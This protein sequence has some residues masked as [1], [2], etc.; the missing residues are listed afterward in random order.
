MSSALVAVTDIR[1]PAPDGPAYWT[2]SFYVSVHGVKGHLSV[3]VEYGA[4]V[5]ENILKVARNRFRLFAG[6][7]A[8]STARYALTDDQLLKLRKSYEP[9]PFVR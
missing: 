6:T 8:D 3:P 2:V 7:V 1:R 9:D 5:G 4:F